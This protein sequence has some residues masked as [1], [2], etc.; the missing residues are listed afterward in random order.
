MINEL[1]TVREGRNVDLR[2]VSKEDFLTLYDWRQDL[3]AFGMSIEHSGQT[4]SYEHFAAAMNATLR[5]TI[6][7]LAVRPDDDEPIGLVQAYS[8]NHL[9]GWC[10]VLVYICPEFRGKWAGREAGL[11]FFDYM[12]RVFSMRK[13]HVEVAEY[14]EGLGEVGYLNI[15]FTQEGL[16]REHKF[17]DG[18]YWDVRFLT[19]RSERWNDVRETIFHLFRI[20]NGDGAAPVAASDAETTTRPAQASPPPRQAALRWHLG[21]RRTETSKRVELVH[22]LVGAWREGRIEG[23][24]DRMA[25]S[26]AFDAQTFE[27]QG[28]EQF[29][30]LMRAAM[31]L[32]ERTEPELDDEVEIA[33]TAYEEDGS[34]V[35]ATGMR[36]A[37]TIEV[38]YEFDADDKVCVMAFRG[39]QPLIARYIRGDGPAPLAG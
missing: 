38:F 31:Q 8:I 35:A 34:S 26:I 20:E 5:E 21:R 32:A 16:F 18:R 28:K 14:N 19:L 17:R 39:D 7:L 3:L 9:Q 6:V 27:A 33:W 25:D 4:A 2:S 22:Q 36:G 15:V 29:E 1:G 12:F 24:M 37:D 30:R 13:L 11:I 10:L 23:V